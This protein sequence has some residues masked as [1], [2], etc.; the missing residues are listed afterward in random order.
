MMSEVNNAKIK[1]RHELELIQQKWQE[2]EQEKKNIVQLR[3]DLEARENRLV[4]LQPLIPS[5]K[6]LQA[7]GIDINQFLPWI[8]TIH[9]KAEIEKIDIKL[10]AYNLAQE[11][12]LYRQLQGLQKSLQLTQK[13]L[14]MLNVAILQKQQAISTLISL[15][16]AGMTDSEIVELIK[17][18]KMWNGIG[19]GTGVNIFGQGNGGGSR[20]KLDD[21][22]MRQGPDR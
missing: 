22:L 13:Q 10:A 7:Y 18:V 6:Q 3:H 14:E 12:R 19:T 8:E 1:R 21:K 16:G 2:L 11:L 5:A 15:Q 17:L 20:S 4:E 9:E